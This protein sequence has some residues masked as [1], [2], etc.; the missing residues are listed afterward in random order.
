MSNFLL[1]SI[2]KMTFRH[3]QTCRNKLT[4]SSD[5]L[6]FRLKE[7]FSVFR[8]F[9]DPW[10][11]SIKDCTFLYCSAVEEANIFVQLSLDITNVVWQLT[12]GT[13]KAVD[14]KL[15]H[16]TAFLNIECEKYIN[17]EKKCVTT[18]PILPYHLK[19]GNNWKWRRYEKI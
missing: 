7:K 1:C 12:P 6:M 17:L 18:S 10:N 2:V 16:I 3:K 15:W 19:I 9:F 11:F 13:E 5:T 4:L 8:N 14:S